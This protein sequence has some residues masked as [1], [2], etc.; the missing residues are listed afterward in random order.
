[1]EYRLG[2]DLG[3]TYTAAAI[4]RGG[5]PEMVS[6]GDHELFAP[7]VIV[8][9]PDGSVLVGD[10]AEQRS[11]TSADRTV[12]EFKARLG[13]TTPV[14]L[15]G[16]AYSAE[17][18][19]ARLLRW[20]LDLVHEREGGPPA[21][22]AVTYPAGWA[23]HRRDRL[24]QVLAEAGVRDPV[25]VTEP[26]AAAVRYAST[27]RIHTGDVVGVYDLGG[28]TFDAAVLRRGP[29][30]FELLGRPDGMTDF[31]GAA[32][33]SWV[34][35]HVRASV[36][37]EAFDLDPA[38]QTVTLAV[39]RLRREC[40]L[41]KEA[42]SRETETTIPVI[43]PSLN[44]VV[45][46]TRAELEEGIRPDVEQTIV[47]FRRAL[48]SAGL[49]PEDLA[50]VLVAGGSSRIPLVRELLTT[51]L[52]RPV[53]GDAHPKHVVALGA[54]MRAAPGT[55]PAAQAPA[56]GPQV[57][58]PRPVPGPG[59]GAG[60]GAG[61]GA[62]PA[63]G[64]GPGHAGRPPSAVTH[65]RVESV[66][67]LPPQAG[68]APGRGARRAAGTRPGRLA[69][70]P[71]LASLALALVTVILAVLG[72]GGAPTGDVRIANK[73][74]V[75]PEVRLADPLV[76]S[77]A[78]GVPLTEAT[79]T[80]VLASFDLAGQPVARDGS[81]SL[82]GL[83]HVLAGPFEAAVRPAPTSS[84]VP[85]TR[86]AVVRP[87]GGV[88]SGGLLSIPGVAGVALL[89]FAFAYAESFLRP[90]R[91]GRPASNGTLLGMGTVGFAAGAG[92]ALAGWVL[93][94]HLLNLPLLLLCGALGLGT[95]LA[96]TTAVTRPA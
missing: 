25:F 46:L 21:G 32:I 38:D 53:T 44:T 37:E 2:V 80:P 9:N 70:G 62:R 27:G 95:S 96:F 45:R 26:E 81:L 41:A 30:A 58:V 93:G 31:G 78:D 55:R 83:R 52:G 20:V 19:M 51:E 35:E 16:V 22:V 85:A 66:R 65:V 13:D 88:L 36:G 63:A 59:A 15:G 89:M 90:L 40:V 17:S 94:D 50:A 61:P 87:A 64:P 47:A 79:L 69:R 73:L 24:A 39:H 67:D 28:G 7:S 29:H 75:T 57:V 8:V 77:G 82:R 14:L 48:S 71:G 5:E 42:L 86:T 1:M 12:R 43:L 4:L 68:H 76:A 49:E 91:K 6:L 23:Q 34:F 84:A 3:T 92:M 72:F 60:A 10:P 33:D 54:A 11:A 74:A 56:P 18:L